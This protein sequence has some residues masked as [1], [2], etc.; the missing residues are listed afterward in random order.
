MVPT[1]E[2]VSQTLCQQEIHGHYRSDEGSQFICSRSLYPNGD[3]ITA[4]L[5]PHGSKWGFT[6]E[7]I[8]SAFLERTGVELT[9][10]RRDAIRL[11][12]NA[13]NMEW[14][15]G[16]FVKAPVDLQIASRAFREFCDAVLRISGMEFEHHLSE[17]EL[18]VPKVDAV[19]RRVTASRSELRSRYVDE[20]YD[21]D[22]LYPI[23]WAVFQNSSRKHVFAISGP[24]STLTMPAAV[25]YLRLAGLSVPTLAV[26]SPHIK[27]TRRNTA[28]IAK[29][30]Q[31]I[32]FRDVYEDEERIKNWLEAA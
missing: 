12:L 28:R 6:D 32:I 30:A 9:D 7:G 13:H 8:T 24:L 26:V 20:F 22:K 31:D 3:T 14:Q 11:I 15:H 10:R 17:R 5:M 4:F 18:Y 16:A 2:Q 19:L 23:D 21:P 27:L 25:N 29:A 1:I